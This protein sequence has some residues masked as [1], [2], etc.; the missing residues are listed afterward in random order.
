MQQTKY[1]N[2]VTGTPVPGSKK[3]TNKQIKTHETDVTWH[4]A[5]HSC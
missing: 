1:R 4:E 2:N 5:Y 3:K